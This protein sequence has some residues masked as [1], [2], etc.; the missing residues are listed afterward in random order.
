MII[1]HTNRF[2]FLHIP[3]C[4]GSTVRSALSRYDEYMDQYFGRAVSLHSVLGPLDYHHIPLPVLRDYFPEDFSCLERYRTFTLLRDPFLRFPSS[5]H[6]RFFQRDCKPLDQRN[7]IE[8]SREV[9]QVMGALSRQ[10]HNVPILDPEL[11]HF[12]RQRDY[13]YCD[14]RKIVDSLYRISDIDLLLAEIAS[15]TGD[16]LKLEEGKNRRLQFSSPIVERMQAAVTQPIQRILPRHIWKP[17]FRSIKN[18][19]IK[20][21]WLRPPSNPLSN[22]PNAHEIEA[23]IADFYSKDIELF[24]S[25][26]IAEPP[27]VT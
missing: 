9:D 4:A 12:S 20:L 10:P 3:K 2:V 27:Q 7:I 18:T 13:V 14:D 5:L 19:L 1:C 23:F 21:D 17:A 11:I 15:I 16:P 6:E 25:V 8:I 26:V 22:L 24:N